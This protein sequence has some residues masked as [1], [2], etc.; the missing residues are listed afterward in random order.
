MKVRIVQTVPVWTFPAHISKKGSQLIQ[1]HVDG[2]DF[3][4]RIHGKK[5][6]STPHVIHT[7]C[8]IAGFVPQYIHIY[9]AK[10]RVMTV[11]MKKSSTP[12]PACRLFKQ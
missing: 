4:V 9:P 7:L 8:D 12:H 5:S 3:L 10:D 1:Q 11:Y 2:S 6:L